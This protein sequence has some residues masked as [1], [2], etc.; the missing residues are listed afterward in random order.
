LHPN[1]NTWPD[2]TDKIF[3]TIGAGGNNMVIVPEYNIILSNAN[4]D[5]GNLDARC[6]DNTFITLFGC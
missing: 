1:S 6:P 5:C 2:G 4:G 3:I